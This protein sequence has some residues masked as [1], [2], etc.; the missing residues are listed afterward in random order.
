MKPPQIGEVGHMQEHPI[1][2]SKHQQRQRASLGRVYCTTETTWKHLSEWLWETEMMENHPISRS[3]K[4]V[5]SKDT[6]IT[7][8]ETFET[9]RSHPSEQQKNTTNDTKPPQKAVGRHQKN[10]EAMPLSGSLILQITH[11]NTREQLSDTW[12]DTKQPK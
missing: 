9:T 10:T 12:N 2:G 5:Q 3:E 6:Q 7:G 8:F 4:L 1:C 11:N